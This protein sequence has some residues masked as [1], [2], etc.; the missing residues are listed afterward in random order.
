MKKTKRD[1]RAGVRWESLKK[2]KAKKK[3]ALFICT[4][5]TVDY[6]AGDP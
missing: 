2:K 3:K 6:D 4:V 1:T 5:V